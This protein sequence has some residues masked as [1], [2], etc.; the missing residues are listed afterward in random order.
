V[1]RILTLVVATGLVVVACSSS[2]SLTEFAEELDDLVS[3]MNQGLDVADASLGEEPSLE[4][5]RAYVIDRLELRN[6]F[7]DAFRALDSPEE[8]EDLYETALAIISRLV[9][10]ETELADFVMEA[11]TA[12]VARTVWDSPAGDAARAVDIESLAICDA[13]QA[14]IDATQDRDAFSDTPWIPPEMKEVIEITFKCRA[15]DR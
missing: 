2:S 15:G 8:I 6:D 5:M 12:E 14:S 3:T 10:A 4:V 9:A 11:E 13:A 7:L 1:R